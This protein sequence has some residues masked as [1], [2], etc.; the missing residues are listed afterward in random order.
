MK[1]QIVVGLAVLGLAGAVQAADATKFPANAD[2]SPVDSIQ[3]FHRFDSWRPVDRDT[4]IVWVTPSKPYLIEL[5]RPSYDMPFEPAIGVTSMAGIVHAKF[6]NVIV[7][8]MRYPI[9]AI[10]KIDRSTARNLRGSA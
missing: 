9:K 6:D 5:A 7:D 10:Y 4:L 1:K 3:T 2:V 8:G